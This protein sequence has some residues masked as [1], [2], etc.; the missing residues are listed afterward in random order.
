MH[1]QCLLIYKDR[2]DAGNGLYL[3]AFT[4]TQWDLGML[5]EEEDM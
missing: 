5:I 1:L 4:T 3:R 2:I